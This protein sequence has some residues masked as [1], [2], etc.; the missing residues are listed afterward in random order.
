MA[1]FS[2]QIYHLNWSLT[3]S[4]IT[5]SH[6][7][8]KNHNWPQ[9][10]SYRFTNW[11]QLSNL[12]FYLNPLPH[13]KPY[14]STSWYCLTLATT[15]LVSIMSMLLFNQESTGCLQ[16]HHIMSSGESKSAKMVV[17][18]GENIYD[19]PKRNVAYIGVF[20]FMTLQT[21]QIHMKL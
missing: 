21:F 4:R 14:I 20:K 11:L 2:K 12:Y 17:I 18:D 10:W 7:L 6:L 1:Q 13:R 3:I 19:S 5:W 15:V 8:R 9:G 16:K